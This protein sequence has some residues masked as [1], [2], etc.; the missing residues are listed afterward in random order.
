MCLFGFHQIWY[1]FEPPHVRGELNI[2][3][4]RGAQIAECTVREASVEL[5][6]FKNSP[7]EGIKAEDIQFSKPMKTTQVSGS[8][9]SEV[10]NQQYWKKMVEQTRM[11]PLAIRCQNNQ[12]KGDWEHCYDEEVGDNLLE[13]ESTT[14]NE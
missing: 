3:M 13:K 6:A 1:Q 8:K 10:A 7:E 11:L 9:T 2:Q 12:E 4:L 5:F 14:N